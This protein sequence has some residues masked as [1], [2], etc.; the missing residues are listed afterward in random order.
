VEFR[1]AD[2]AALEA[3]VARASAALGPVPLLAPAQFTRDRAERERHWKL[4]KGLFPSVGGMRPSGTAVVIEDVVFPVPR[5]AAAIADLRA[6]FDRHEFSDAI[7]FGHARDGNLHFV[8]A[9]DFADPPTVRRYDAFMRGLVE[10]VVGKYDGA[11]KAEHGSGRNMAPFVRDEWGDRAYEVMRR[12]KALLDPD[13]IFNPDAVLSDDPEIHLKHLKPLPP[14]SPLADR[15]IECGFCEPRCPSR[16]L[17][18]TPRQRIVVHRE[19]VRLAALGTREA[20]EWAGSLRE[21]FEYEGIATCAVD[22]MCSTSCPVKIDTGALIKETRAAAHSAFAQGVAGT[23]ARHFGA[24]ARGARLGLRAAQVAGGTAVGRLLLSAASAQL[25]RALPSVIPWVR[26]DT[27][28]PRPAPGL[29]PLR[30][31]AG[32]GAPRVVYFPSC[33]TRIIGPLPGEDAP[34]AAQAML[35]VLGAAGFDV[36]YPDG[37]GALCCGMPFS[38][39]AFFPAARAAARRTAGALWAAAREGADPV[40]TDAS[41]CAGSLA[42]LAV[43]ALAEDGRRLA[44]YDFPAF[45]AA[46]ALARVG[47]GRRRPGTAVLHPTCTLV[48]SGGLPDLV[49]V[50][51]AHSEAVMVPAAAECCGFAGDRGFLVPELTAA[52][53]AREAGEVLETA[54]GDTGLY[55]TCRTCEIGMSRAVGRPYRSLVHL[56]QEALAVG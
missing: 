52:A 19:L 14:I 45:W 9:R 41:P 42:D 50:A 48:K 16:D 4:R 38:S 22:S 26:A 10:L 17:T 39:K 56:V 31:S 24:V 40:V 15:C 43:A 53:T 46:H 28:V 32:G 23:A 35:D 8:F 36:V 54:P 11:L 30:R 21:D 29:P 44:V 34:P 27:K 3:A 1:E 7:V 6:L 12:I 20:R 47:E 2:E 37:I 33:L 49:R 51:R 5:L 18:L 25:H 13:G 55:S